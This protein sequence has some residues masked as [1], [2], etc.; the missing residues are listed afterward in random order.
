MKKNALKFAIIT[1]SFNQDQFISQTIESVL[2]QNFPIEYWIID[3]GSTD[4]TSK[5]VQSYGKRVHFISEKD[6]G[7]ADALNKGLSR[8][9]LKDPKLVVA[10][11]NSDDYYAFGAFQEVVCQF[12]SHPNVAWLVGD[13]MI[14]NEINQ[15]IQTAVRLYKK[16][17]RCLLNMSLLQIVNPIPQPAVF[18]RASAIA[19]IGEFNSNLQYT[20]DYE[21]WLRMYKAF[22]KPLCIQKTL[23]A[24]RIHSRSKGKNKFSDQFKEEN[25]VA[26]RFTSN[27]IIKHLHRLHN[28]GIITIYGLI[29]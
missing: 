10:Y 7:Q 14:V 28:L 15:P 20:M 24:F 4:D 13:V 1:P 11:I 22:G 29:K 9:N 2:S 5:V 23:A 26:S 8:F 25:E 12:K 18:I 27:P 6:R 3:G 16:V 19:K 17:L 21:Y